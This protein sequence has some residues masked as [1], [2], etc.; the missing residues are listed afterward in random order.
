M[1]NLI[2]FDLDG[3]LVDTKKNHYIALNEALKKF[4]IKK[5]ISYEDH[6][7][8]FD[9][10]PTYEKLKIL[11]KEG[12][13]D[14]K[15]NKSVHKYKQIFTKKSLL[16]NVHY[17][18]NIFEI[19]KKL[20]KKVKIA[21]ATNATKTTLDICINKLKI[22]KFIDF[23]ISNENLKNPKPNPEIYLKVFIKFG[24]YPKNVLIIEDSFVG[25]EAAISSGANLLAIKHLKEVNYKNIINSINKNG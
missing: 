9:G 19:F 6:L 12:V 14:V 23:T 2:I 3:V 4:G 22:R 21:I 24:F 25:R 1:I 11:N 7:R 16:K 13:L 5:T 15:L 8:K 10:L 17:N 18:K 20:S